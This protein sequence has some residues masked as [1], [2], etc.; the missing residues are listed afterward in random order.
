M[1]IIHGCFMGNNNSGP[2]DGRHAS[3]AGSDSAAEYIRETIR[4]DTGRKER[5]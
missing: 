5:K 2:D 3:P 4:M 1:R